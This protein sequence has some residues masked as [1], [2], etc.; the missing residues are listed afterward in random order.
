MSLE[1]PR[2]Q[3]M[4]TAD[5]APAGVDGEILGEPQ[6]GVVYQPILSTQ[7]REIVGFHAI[8]RAADDLGG[9][10]GD[11]LRM[12]AADKGSTAQ[13]DWLFRATAF[14]DMLNADLP[15][16]LSI[17]VGIEPETLDI[18]CPDTLAGTVAKA[19]TQL[20]VLIEFDGPALLAN[21]AGTLDAIHRARAARWGVVLRG[22]ADHPP[23][24]A[25]LD[26]VQ[27]DV[28]AI[29][30][31]SLRRLDV[32][33]AARVLNNCLAYRQTAGASLLTCSVDQHEQ[34]RD[35]EAWQP[36]FLQGALFGAA[37]AT[38]ET[39]KPPMRAIPLI[40][41]AAP[42]ITD[43]PYDT[44]AATVTSRRLTPAQLTALSRTLE[45]RCLS[46]AERPIVLA[47]QNHELSLDRLSSTGSGTAT[48]PTPWFT[49]TLTTRPGNAPSDNVIRVRLPKADPIAGQRILVIS[50]D[51]FAAVLAA[52]RRATSGRDDRIDVVLSY[53]RATVTTV[54]RAL[55]SRIPDTSH[56]C[57]GRPLRA[58]PAPSLPPADQTTPR[59]NDSPKRLRWARLRQLA[60]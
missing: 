4:S 37:G 14:Q 6:V 45:H 50:S 18:A 21:P 53:D 34:L 38:L 29:D 60:Q 16:A 20:R 46:L 22:L 25:L 43:D 35:I 5:E 13:W 10:T 11:R 49:A 15:A 27:P 52:R 23:A 39:T 42:V 33:S 32:A 56:A 17:V 47:C 48:T 54:A 44:V 19:T 3:T 36:D 40:N 58:R 9:H 24:A 55:L 26:V 2:P 57:A 59:T 51:D 31:A 30:L 7:H 1:P 12:L 28:I 41:T 8:A